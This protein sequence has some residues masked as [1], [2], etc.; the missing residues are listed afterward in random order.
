MLQTNTSRHCSAQ[1]F[2]SD[3]YCVTNTEK[4]QTDCLCHEII[5]EKVVSSTTVKRNGKKYFKLDLFW[6]LI[7][8]VTQKLSKAGSKFSV[9]EKK[10]IDENTVEFCTMGRQAWYCSVY[11]FKQVLQTQ[12]GQNIKVRLFL[13]VTEDVGKKS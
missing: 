1:L 6:S 4:D 3:T 12:Y 8:V 5:N 9:V 11:I 7:N 10:C 2:C 13:G